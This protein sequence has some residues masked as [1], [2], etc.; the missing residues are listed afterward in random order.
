[1][2]V[3]LVAV[4]V[5]VLQLVV[6][7]RQVVKVL[8][9]VM[10]VLVQAKVLQATHTAQVAVVVHQPLVQMQQFRVQVMVGRELLF[11]LLAVQ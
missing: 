1:M 7:L 9:V 2:L 3:V 4:A 5:M 11:Q 10:V 6:L 8:R